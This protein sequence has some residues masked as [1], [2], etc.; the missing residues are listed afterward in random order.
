[1]GLVDPVAEDRRRRRELGAGVDA[2]GLA[3]VGGDVRRDRLPRL[4]EQADHVGQVELA[5]DVVWLEPVEQQ[6]EGVVAEDVDRAVDLADLELLDGRVPALRDPEDVARGIADDPPV[7]PRVGGDGGEDRRRCALAPVRLDELLEQRRREQRRVAGEDEHVLGS[8]LD[9]RP[10]GADGVARALRLLLD[11]DLV[12]LEPLPGR[13]RRDHDE[14]VGA[15]AAAGLEHPV[16][17]PA[18]EQLVEVL[19][20]GGFHPRAEA[21][22]HHDC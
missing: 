20:H 12:A 7:C 18:A 19:R 9:R 22:G 21:R 1:V 17:H 4:D 14:R 11:R 5:L 15:D 16:D 2:V 10:G 3:R 6:P 8:T 13:G